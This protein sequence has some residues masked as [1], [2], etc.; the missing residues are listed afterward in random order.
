[1]DD[2]PRYGYLENSHTTSRGRYLLL[3]TIG[4][5]ELES[6]HSLVLRRR[7]DEES[8]FA[9][10]LQRRSSV[11]LETELTRE[12]A[13]DMEFAGHAY[14]REGS[15]FEVT[16]ARDGE[17][18][19]PS[20]WWTSAASD[21]ALQRSSKFRSDVR[22][23]RVDDETKRRLKETFLL[24]NL[25]QGVSE[26]EKIT[27]GLSGTSEPIE[28][29]SVYNVGQGSAAALCSGSGVP[30][31]F[32]DYGWPLPANSASASGPLCVPGSHGVE[33]VPIVLS[34]WDMDHWYGVSANSAAL[35][36]PWYVP[37]YKGNIGTMALQ[38]AATLASKG[39]LFIVPDLGDL[40]LELVGRVGQ[41]GRTGRNCDGRGDGTGRT[42]GTARTL[43]DG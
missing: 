1:L 36:V 19:V 25:G 43:R 28:V 2:F 35:D 20:T 31:V 29:V 38:M 4:R 9:S 32:F 3:D 12:A 21:F 22:V 16:P 10:V 40:S 8:G 6:L 33:Q 11:I 13:S 42:A 18:G 14:P 23:S 15:W 24:A 39:L 37:D 34:H 7:G 26:P 17:F 41:I 5:S 27:E 30:Q